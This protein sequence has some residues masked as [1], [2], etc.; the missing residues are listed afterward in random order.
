MAWAAVGFRNAKKRFVFEIVVPFWRHLFDLGCHCNVGATAD[1]FGCW[2][3]VGNHCLARYWQNLAPKVNQRAIKM[4]Q[5]IDL[6]S[7]FHKRREGFLEM[8][9]C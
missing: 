4:H 2:Q 9:T 1:T 6:V 7:G 8:S 3:F 5:Q